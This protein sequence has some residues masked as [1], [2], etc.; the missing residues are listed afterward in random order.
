MRGILLEEKCLFLCSWLLGR[1][2]FR[3]RFCSGFRCRLRSWLLSSWFFSYGRLRSSFL[4]GRT[5]L[6][7][8]FLSNTCE[9]SLT[10]GSGVLWQEVLLDHR[11]E[12]TL[13]GAQVLCVRTR[14]K[15]LHGTLEVTLGGYVARTSLGGLSHTL[16]S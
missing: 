11:V 9:L 3:S 5:G 2:L 14:Q 4:G 8:S 1:S 15:C 16:D 6:D 13:S 12:F 10:A 7:A